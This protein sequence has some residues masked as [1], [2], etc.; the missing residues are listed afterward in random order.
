[1][2]T[3]EAYLT[4]GV[5]KRREGVTDNFP[6]REKAVIKR[7]DRA[8]RSR[9]IQ[10]QSHTYCTRKSSWTIPLILHRR[11]TIAND[12]RCEFAPRIIVPSWWLWKLAPVVGWLVAN[13]DATNSPIRFFATDLYIYIQRNV[14][15][16]HLEE[17][18]EFQNRGV[19]FIIILRNDGSI[20]KI[21]HI[22]IYVVQYKLV[23]SIL[24]SKIVIKTAQI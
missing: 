20:V 13:R 11:Q 12:T 15:E 7:E 19:R 9:E 14:A 17:E 2:I 22:Y 1:M 21:L 23:E 16:I 3:C 18:I 5:G 4:E 8:D 6:R 24:E 10:L